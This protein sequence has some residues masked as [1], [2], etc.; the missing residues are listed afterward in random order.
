VLVE[1]I[2]SAHD[3]SK[4]IDKEANKEPSN[5]QVVQQCAIK[6]MI[7]DLLRTTC[8]YCVGITNV[9]GICMT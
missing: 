9:I 4:D 5:E 8:D 2:I 1:L 6:M 7:H 3:I